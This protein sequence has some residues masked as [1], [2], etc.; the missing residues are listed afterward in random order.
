MARNQFDREEEQKRQFK[1]TYAIGKMIEDAIREEVSE[2]L[3]CVP[4]EIRTD[5]E[6]NGQDIIIRYKGHVL[7]YLECKAKW[8]FGDNDRAHMSSQQMKQAVRNEKRYALLCVDCTESTG[9][10]V[11]LDATKEQIW[12]SR[13][14][15]RLHT[16][17]QTEIGRILSP[18]IK[19]QVMHE[20]DSSLNEED[21][22]R[23]YSSLTCNISKKVFIGG[24]PFNEFMSDLKAN[25]K[26]Q[27]ED[28]NQ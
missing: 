18:I 17:V 5:D 20:D 24:T 25:L 8:R 7:Y 1:F 26:R 21:T 12:E 4:E 11:P 15:I 6:Q 13:E 9:A 14:D 2:Q 16:H 27:I 28:L 3:S 22:I 19:A 23:V 10:H